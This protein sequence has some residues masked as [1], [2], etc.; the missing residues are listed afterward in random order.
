MSR[1][2]ILALAGV[3]TLT[4]IGLAAPVLAQTPDF[5]DD[6]SPWANDSECDDPRFQGEG[7]TTTPLLE[8]DS[9]ADATDCRNAF[10]AGTITLLGA[11]ATTGGKGPATA[12]TTPVTAGGINF[13]DDSNEWANDGECDDRRFIGPGMATSIAWMN[14]GRDASDCQSMMDSGD[15]RLFVLADSVAATTCSAI[16][17]GDDSGGFPNDGECDDMRMEGTG[18]ASIINS[19]NN[20]RDA[21]DCQRLCD[22]GMIGLRDY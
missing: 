7:M 9:G 12:V 1:T 14:V 2:L 13:G 21:S 22:F 11:V 20:F 3:A 6:S 16:D 19:D 10:N 8:S 4:A 18:M 17:F 15:V 5:G